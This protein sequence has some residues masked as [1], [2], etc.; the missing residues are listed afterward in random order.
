MPAT[1]GI[2]PATERELDLL[3]SVYERASF[4]PRLAAVDRFARVALGGEVFV[5]ERDDGLAGASGCAHFG[6]TGWVGAVAVVPEARRA[7]LGRAL[8]EAAVAW[9]RERGAGTI[10]LYATD[11]GRPIYELLGF[12][13][14][15]ACVAFG[16]RWQPG[17]PTGAVRAAGPDDLQAAQAVD[18]EATGEDRAALLTS[19]WPGSALVAE[20]GGEV[21]GYHL[22]S[23][24]RSGGATVAADLASGLAL[25]EAAAGRLN[26]AELSLSIPQGNEPAIR[27]LEARG[28]TERSRA[29]R[30]RL[31]PPLVWRPRAVFSTFNLFWG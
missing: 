26:G 31:G 15:G 5:V 12:V 29:T 19:L 27:A 30:M 3:P 13:A 28:Q 2:R 18:R 22:P 24:W 6:A 4:N 20:A 25:I 17:P 9:L 16:G 23:P 11:M 7:G 10:Q 21:R 8:T 1:Q 14:E